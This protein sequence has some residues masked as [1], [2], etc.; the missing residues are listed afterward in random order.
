MQLEI[1]MSISRYFPA[2]G[3]AGLDRIL[4]KGDRRVPRPPP[5]TIDTT[6]RSIKSDPSKIESTVDAR[7]LA[8]FPGGFTSAKK[9]ITLLARA[10]DEYGTETDT[11]V[12]TLIDTQFNPVDDRRLRQVFSTSVGLRNRLP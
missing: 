2:S 9:E 7:I 3:T 5:N 4:V 12:Y 8:G 10:D 1:G 11:G 6:F